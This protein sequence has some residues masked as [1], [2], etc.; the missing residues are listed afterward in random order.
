MGWLVHLLL[1]LVGGLV[2]GTLMG[3]VS[4][5]FWLE[6]YEISLCIPDVSLTRVRGMACNPWEM[7][8]IQ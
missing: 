3:N 4:S 7:R 5:G 6:R 2:T 8:Y 1:Y